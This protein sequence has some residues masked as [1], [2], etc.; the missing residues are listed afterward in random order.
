MEIRHHLLKEAIH[1]KFKVDIHSPTWQTFWKKGK[2]SIFYCYLVN[3][4][5]QIKEAQ[6][7]KEKFAFVS[8]NTFELID[9]HKLAV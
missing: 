4:W 8:E 6:E 1:R 7:H 2:Q 3:G 9:A 5:Q